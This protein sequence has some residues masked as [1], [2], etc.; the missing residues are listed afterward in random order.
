MNDDIKIKEKTCKS[1]ISYIKEQ[2]EKNKIVKISNVQNVIS[3]AL[4]IEYLERIYS[5]SV[6]EEDKIT[7]NIRKLKEHFKNPELINNKLHAELLNYN[8]KNYTKIYLYRCLLQLPEEQWAISDLMN[9]DPNI[10]NKKSKAI[11]LYVVKFFIIKLGFTRCDEIAYSAA[12]IIKNNNNSSDTD[13]A[14]DISSTGLIPR[15]YYGDVTG[16]SDNGYWILP[17]LPG[18]IVFFLQAPL[19]INFMGPAYIYMEID[20]LNCID[21]TSPYSLTT[22][23][24]TTNQ[25]NGICNSAFAK[26]PVPTTPIS[27]W[28]DSDMTPYKY[29]N[30]PAERIRKLKIK[31]RYHNNVLVDFGSFDFSFMLE[32]C[33]LRPQNERKFNIRDAFSLAQ[34]QG[35]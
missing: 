27:Q 21:E 35:S 23:T 2:I 17:V 34:T 9:Y 26:I 3:K 1:Y 22:F 15:F 6:T 30:P 20:G 31:F 28:F 25:T 14:A 18:A 12:E 7:N 24:A 16:T 8:L 13:V 5:S 19:K 10:Y 4:H 33:I 11:I 29:F 32:I